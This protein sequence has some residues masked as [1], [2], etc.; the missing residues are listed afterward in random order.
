MR[1]PS[2]GFLN[3]EFLKMLHELVEVLARG[4]SAY[5]LFPQFTQFGMFDHVDFP[6]DGSL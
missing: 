5:G 3:I 1:I 6:G 4:S 2:P